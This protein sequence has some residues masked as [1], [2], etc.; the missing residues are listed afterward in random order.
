[1]EAIGLKHTWTIVRARRSMTTE[2]PG[3]PIARRPRRSRTYAIMFAVCAVAYL[4]A[5][6]V[7]KVLVPRY[8]AAQRAPGNLAL[9]TFAVLRQPARSP[10]VAPP[11]LQAVGYAA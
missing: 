5:W 9:Q 4:V 2:V 11:L 6:T 3:N 8:R 7:M 10:K 1:V